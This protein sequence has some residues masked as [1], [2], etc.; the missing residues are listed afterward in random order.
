MFGNWGTIGSPSFFRSVKADGSPVGISVFSPPS[1]PVNS[2]Y[3]KYIETD[4]QNIEF[5]KTF[6][7]G[8]RNSDAFTNKFIQLEADYGSSTGAQMRSALINDPKL[9]APLE[10]SV[11][12]EHMSDI[13]TELGR[14]ET[15][16]VHVIEASVNVTSALLISEH[17]GTLPVTD[18]PYF[19]RLLALRTFDSAYIGG[20]SRLAPFLGYEIAKAVIPDE[21]LQHLKIFEI[22]E[23]REK[24]KDAYSAWS[25]EI[26]RV[27]SKVD[28]FDPDHAE[29]IRRLIATELAPQITEFRNEMS[30]VRDK[31]FGNMV[32]SVSKW[33]LPALTLAYLTNLG[34]K[35]AIT[36]FASTL[37]QSVP[38]IVEYIQARRDVSRTHA[39]SYLVG[40]ADE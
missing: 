25:T 11:R 15:L 28:Q 17:T 4:I 22:L 30:S 3:Q 39:V 8:L 9:L 21:V 5:I 7:D 26:N 36:I 6:L 34:V 32:K 14:R 35:G 27:S 29:E 40:L 16:K 24:S 12:Q 33:Q 10:S 13:H 31:L 20:V 23:Y 2:L 19:S 37:V 1:G 38:S 18:D